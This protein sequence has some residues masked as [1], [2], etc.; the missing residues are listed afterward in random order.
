MEGSECSLS[1]PTRVARPL[2]PLPS[3]MLHPSSF[4][5]QHPSS[6]CLILPS[7]A[8]PLHSSSPHP[9]SFSHRP[10]LHTLPSSSWLIPFPSFSFSPSDAPGSRNRAERIKAMGNGWVGGA[11]LSVTEGFGSGLVC[12][13]PRPQASPRSSTY[14]PVI[15][16]GASRILPSCHLISPSYHSIFTEMPQPQEGVAWPPR[17]TPIF[18]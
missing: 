7:S 18:S 14:L 8:F 6:P 2:L 15:Q 5:L 10:S 17:A 9:T 16:P 13:L 4:I 3:S 12:F 1:S 11:V